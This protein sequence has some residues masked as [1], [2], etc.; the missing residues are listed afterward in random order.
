MNTFD[1]ITH[2]YKIAD[3]PVPSITQII[4]KQDYHQSDARLE[5]TRQEGE[6]NHSMIKMFFDNKR[7]TF[8][9][10]M[11]IAFK[12]WLDE[13]AEMLGELKLYEEHLYSTRFMFGGT[14]DAIFENAIVEIKRSPGDKL[15]RA[16][17]IAGQSILSHENKVAHKTKKWIVAW[18][19]N[20][21]FKSKNV[22]NDK[23][24]DV[25]IGLVKKHYIDKL[26]N[27]YFKK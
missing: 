16:L 2:I 6:D 20:G 4:P 15:I 21:K 8:K 23:A 26:L 7:E 13:N 24:E 12:D 18:Y 19:E 3:V 22:F 1:E 14:P 5:E 27:D 10:P 11:L 17:Q 25:F 9:D